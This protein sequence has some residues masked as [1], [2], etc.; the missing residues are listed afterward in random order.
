MLRTVNQTIPNERMG[1]MKKLEG[2]L[3]LITGSSRG[4]GQKT[5]IALAKEGCNIIVHGRK[6]EN[7]FKTIELLK[8]TGVKTYSVSGE[9]SNPEAVENIIETVKNKIG[10]IDILYNNAAIMAK[11][12]PIWEIPRKDW[13]EIMQINFYTPVQFCTA[14]GQDMKS[15]RYG[16]IVNLTTG[17][18]NQ[19]SLCP[20]SVSK[21]ALDKFTKE[22]AFE[23]KD[24]GVLVNMLDPGWLKTDL[25]GPNADHEVDT[26]IPGAIVPALLDSDGVTGY[27]F[28]A[29]DYNKSST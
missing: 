20:Y 23:L 6:E 7:T 28:S 15:K 17:M 29:Q 13:D 4:I 14:F 24:T 22:L 11:F 10:N 19:P 27:F 21:V 5:A 8:E 25:G 26:V 16:R 2:K 9:L 1:S 3:A 12:K 18:E